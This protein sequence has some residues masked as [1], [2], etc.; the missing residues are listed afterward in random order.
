MK[1]LGFR[2]LGRTPANQRILAGEFKQPGLKVVTAG[3][4]VFNLLLKCGGI[5]EI[6]SLR[7]L[8]LRRAGIP[9]QTFDLYDLLIK[10]N[11]RARYSK[12]DGFSCLPSETGFG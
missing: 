3:S 6:A 5:N 1:A 10:E 7:S 2:Y 8:V 4:S 11:A 12:M 9:A